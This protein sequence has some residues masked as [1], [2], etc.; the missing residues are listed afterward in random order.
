[1]SSL[2]G[3]NSLVSILSQRTWKKL[4]PSYC[5]MKTS[6]LHNNTFMWYYMAQDWKINSSLL[7]YPFCY[8][9]NQYC[10][11]NSSWHW[12]KS[13]WMP[14]FRWQIQWGQ[15]EIQFYV[16]N[17]TL[18]RVLEKLSKSCHPLVPW[19]PNKMRSEASGKLQYVPVAQ[20]VGRLIKVS[21]HLF[22]KIEGYTQTLT[23]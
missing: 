6:F 15:N 9:L 8:L 13:A 19:T 7:Q 5:N 17:E 11:M 1:M 4:I 12:P 18:S 2:Y 21:A 20:I 16:G 10:P 3:K 23:T 22:Y 14:T